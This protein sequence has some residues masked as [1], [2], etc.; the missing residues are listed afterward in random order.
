MLHRVS[1]ISLFLYFV[2]VINILITQSGIKLDQ[3]KKS[4]IFFR[5]HL[6]NLKEKKMED[7]TCTT[8]MLYTLHSVLILVPIVM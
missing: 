6:L 8:G 3:R 7:S 5:F 2:N 1:S 4:G